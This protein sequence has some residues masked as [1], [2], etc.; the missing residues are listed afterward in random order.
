M[1]KPL[2]SIAPPAI[3]MPAPLPRVHPIGTRL[4]EA[5]VEG[6]RA[7]AD[8]AAVGYGES[9]AGRDRRAA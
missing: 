8:R 6:Q 2:A 3:L 1:E 4:Q 7:G 5:A 9:T